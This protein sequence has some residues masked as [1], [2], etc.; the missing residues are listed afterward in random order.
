MLKSIWIH[1][2]YL[3]DKQLVEIRSKQCNVNMST[4]SLF[5]ECLNFTSLKKKYILLTR[6]FAFKHYYPEYPKQNYPKTIIDGKLLN[7]IEAIRYT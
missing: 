7:W 5:K 1:Y 4:Y 2:N 3:K 6:N